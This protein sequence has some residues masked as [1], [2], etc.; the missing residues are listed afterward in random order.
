M[1]ILTPSFL[2]EKMSPAAEGAATEAARNLAFCAKKHKP[3]WGYFCLYTDS[4]YFW[5][6]VDFE[7]EQQH[8]SL[9]VTEDF[10]LCKVSFLGKYLVGHFLQQTAESGESG[11]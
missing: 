5:Q 4:D 7:T 2:V 3:A 11:S 8:R 1:A 6:N 9:T 10:F